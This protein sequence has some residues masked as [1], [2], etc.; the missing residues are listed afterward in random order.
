MKLQ[1]K[2]ATEPRPRRGSFDANGTLM[3]SKNRPRMARRGSIEFKGCR[4]K[5]KR[6]AF[7]KDDEVCFVCGE[8]GEIVWNRPSSPGPDASRRNTTKQSSPVPAPA[9]DAA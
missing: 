8:K 7:L 1:T 4:C 5:G 2:A 3:S 6:K 9:L